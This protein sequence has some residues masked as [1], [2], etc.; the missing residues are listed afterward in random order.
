M[1]M[2]SKLLFSAT[3]IGFGAAFPFTNIAVSSIPPLW[4]ATGR[5]LVAL[6]ALSAFLLLRGHPITISKALIPAYLS[7]GVLTGV[8]PYLLISWG[9]QFIPS[10]LGGVLFASA[11]LLTLIFSFTLFRAPHPSL[12]ALVGALIGLSGVALAFSSPDDLSVPVLQGATVTIMA[13]ASYAVGGLL[14]QR[15]KITDIVAFS[16]VQLVPAT[17]ILIA[18]AWFSARAR[19]DEA[20]STSW[21]ALI[22]LGVGGTSIPLLSLFALIGRE[23][24]KTASLTT[25]FIPFIAILIG[26]IFL[27]E[28]F[29]ATAMLGLLI[30]LVGAYWINVAQ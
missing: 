4:V 8:V 24:A 13:A 7:I 2:I 15:Q 11:P 9:Q 1:P 28:P 14:I 20:T 17:I 16:A 25:F 3:V 22:V 23:G 6:L 19:L 26:V 21:I 5:S 29:S 18:I 12:M 30:A 10:S 27:S